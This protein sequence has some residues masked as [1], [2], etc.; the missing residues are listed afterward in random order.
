MFALTLH[1]GT[2]F[3]N[4]PMKWNLSNRILIRYISTALLLQVFSVLKIFLLLMKEIGEKCV[5]IR[6]ISTLSLKAV[7]VGENVADNVL[8]VV[9]RFVYLERS[10]PLIWQEHCGDIEHENLSFIW[11]Y[12]PLLQYLR[13]RNE[14]CKNSGFPCKE[15]TISV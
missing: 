10:G 8:F 9:R 5:F 14:C 4:R 15:L 7:L 13:P 11:N 3:C 2:L 6:R 12:T 1:T